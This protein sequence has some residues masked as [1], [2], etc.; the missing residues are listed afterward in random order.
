MTSYIKKFIL[1]KPAYRPMAMVSIVLFAGVA[2]VLSLYRSFNHDEFEAIHSGWKIFAG[3]KIYVDFLQQH[4]FMLYYVLSDLIS[5]VGTGVKAI[6]ASRLLSLVM[7]VG[8]AGLVYR[9]AK[10][11]Y[12]KNVALLSVFFLSSTVIFLQKI[13]EVRP[14]VPLVLFELLAVFFLLRFFE[15]KKLWQLLLSATTLFVSF[16]FLQK[17][18]FLI[19]LIG[20][21]FVY[22]LWKKEIVWRDFWIFWGMMAVFSGLFTWYVAITFTWSE[23]FFLNWLINANLLNT[24][25]LYKY[26]LISMGQNPLV[27][28]LFVVGIVEMIRKKTFNIIAFLALGMLSF[29]FATKSPFPQYYLTSMPFIVIVAPVQLF[30]IFEWKKQVAIFL[31][32]ATIAGSLGV[33]YYVSENNKKQLQKIDYVLSITDVNDRVYDGDANF[34]VFH[35]DLDYFWFSTKPKTGV[36]TSYRLMREYDYN[37]YALIDK[38]KPKIISNSFIKTK[39]PAVADNYAKSDRYGDLYLRK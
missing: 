5:L 12:D 34:N 26:F 11:A 3:E 20:L 19:F 38:F 2:L 25:P 30:R 27:W 7:A 32:L 24:F 28:I 9:I 29:I 17:A 4:H 36:L 6:I 22:K 8:V 14:D 37:A 21:I 15:T 35:K 10:I 18:V 39:N 31:M 13:L 33:L 1:Q 16:L 23:Y